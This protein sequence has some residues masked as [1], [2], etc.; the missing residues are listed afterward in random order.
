MKTQHIVIVLLILLALTAGVYALT[1]YNRP[2]EAT[3]GETVRAKGAVQAVDLEK[4]AFDGPMVITIRLENGTSQTIAV[5]SMGLPLCAAYQNNNIADVYK[6]E[7][8][9]EVEVRGV[10]AEDGSIVPC[11]SADHYL[12]VAQ[13]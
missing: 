4:V 3:V 7:V 6:L 10:T 1:A 8:G 5:P 2:G 13:S 9:Q 11:E 12:R